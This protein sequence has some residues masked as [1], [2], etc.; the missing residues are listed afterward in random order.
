MNL[1]SK[2]QQG[3]TALNLSLSDAQ[4][5]KL[6]TYIELLQHWNR[7]HNLT[8]IDNIEEMLTKHLLDSLA[9][10]PHII[11]SRII[12][13]G[14]GPGLPGIPLAICFPEKEIVL[15]DSHTKKIQFLIHTKHQLQL[16]NV[17]VV[18]SRVE[19]YQPLCCFDM[20]TTRAFSQLS[21]IIEK[22]LNLCCEGGIVL[23]MKGS[24]PEQELID[25]KELKIAELLEF[26]I[27][28]LKVPFL[29]A[30][31]HLVIIKK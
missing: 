29:E 11:G 1:L 2:L 4:L 24:Y 16:S 8:A 17:E 12:D 21:D 13:V 10:A 25:V 14:T 7:T 26:E 19:S 31:R 20:V 27:I 22:T 5:T 15:L 30:E 6:I 3:T 9:I 18:K 23:A 28:K